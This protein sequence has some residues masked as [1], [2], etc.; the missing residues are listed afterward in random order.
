[1][2]KNLRGAIIML[3]KYF[4]IGFLAQLILFSTLFG[5]EVEAQLTN[6]VHA[7]LQDVSVKQVF[8]ALKKA[9]NVTIVYDGDAVK[10]NRKVH[11]Q[12][13]NL[14]AG[15]VLDKLTA[16]LGLVYKEIGN[17]IT[18]K[19]KVNET[20][21]PYN[22]PNLPVKSGNAEIINFVAPLTRVFQ[23]QISG[24]VKDS[25]GNALIGVT[26][27]V[28]GTTTG[29]TTDANGHFT[30]EALDNATLVFSYVGYQ[31]KEVTL[32]GQNTINVVLYSS[33]TG[34][35]E[36]I[37]IGYGTQKKSDLTGSVGSVDAKSIEE[38]SPSNVQEALQGKVPGVSVSLSSGRPGGAP[39]I[40]IR[41]FTS[42]TGSNNPLYV[43]DGVIIN[44][45][46][47]TNST[48][49]IDYLNPQ[50]IESIS[51]LKD[52][53]ATAI[54]G[55]RGANGVVI[56]T[57]KQPKKS[58]VRYSGSISIGTLPRE[59]PVLNSEEFLQLEDIAY[60]NA[61]KFGLQ[62]TI[63]DP[64]AKR[65][66]RPDLFDSN[67]NPLYNTNWQ[68]EGTRTAISHEQQLS[69]SGGDQ[70]TNYGGSLGYNS[71]QGIILAS[72]SKKYSG[73]FYVN[74]KINKWLTT[75]GSIN[76]VLSNQSYPQA[77]G[78]TGLV[79]SRQ[80]IESLPI[81]P[82]RY[83]DGSFGNN[84]DYPGM[85]GGGQPVRLSQQKGRHLKTNN[86]IGNAYLKFHLAEGLDFKTTLGINST[87]QEYKYF[88]AP[89]LQWISTDGNASVSN[90][91]IGSWQEESQLTYNTQISDN[92]TFSGL[93]AASW[94]KVTSFSSGA[95][96]S[97][98]NT[99]FYKYNN[100]GAAS[101]SSIPTSGR[102]QHTLNSYFGRINYA[103][104]DKYL[105]TA[106]GR[107]D[108]SS[109]FAKSNRY[110]FFPSGAFAWHLSNESF[111]K[112]N[113]TVSNLKLRISYGIT[114]NSN[115]PNYRIDSKLGNYSY[116][117]G[118]NLVSG[119][120]VGSLANSNL[121]WEK[122]KEVDFGIDLGLMKGRISFTG[123]IY[124]KKSSNILLDAPIPASSG[125]TSVIRNIG[126]MENRGIELS[127]HTR[128]IVNPNFSWTTTFNISMNRNKVLFLVG[129]QDI[130]GSGHTIIREG[131]SVNSFYG[132][133]TMGVW[134]TKQ[135]D[136]A[137]VYG[138]LPGDIIFE[139]MN[140]DGAINT[141]DMTIIGNGLPKGYGSL[142]NTFNYKSLQ[143]LINLQYE[144][145]N[146]VA[147]ESRYSFI[148]RTGIANSLREVLNAWTP[149]HQNTSIPQIRP[150][151][152]YVKPQEGKDSWIYNGSF[153]RAKRIMLSYQF[154]S[155]LARR[156][157]MKNINVFIAADNL[158]LIADYP[159]FDPETSSYSG[160]FT[161]GVDYYS[162]PK[163]RT[164]QFGLSFSL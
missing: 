155:E 81:I 111:L 96:V 164:F 88:A 103:I 98:L 99:L 40:H 85:D 69:F 23:S 136:E 109:R 116:I 153:I 58:E 82:V 87:T 80:I 117:F 140:N 19:R 28:K 141:L 142:I 115:I 29:T 148:D 114:G 162:Y 105:F 120:G 37:V 95:S 38:S 2:K 126:D 33:A 154:P 139:D 156:I 113:A 61:A 35:N 104:N 55:S 47:L 68:K 94:Q 124:Y 76:Y 18:I 143:L 10:L 64:V 145:G 118:G 43:V 15:E 12:G 144:F 67:G 125:Y 44:E 3:S 157:D 46:G 91:S 8:T 77:F 6:P 7:N 78:N 63:K 150:N 25:L 84:K 149:D 32:N 45:S 93:I 100:L 131:E 66:S 14:S 41:G 26:V 160:N 73:R 11:I 146:D 54:Y 137:A 39:S 112:D 59:I 129:G 53:S 17:T 74:S 101:T 135:K 71:Q 62:G 56:I 163:A 21:N 86:A 89:N 159:G 70:N 128:N 49:P 57:T 42:I 24:T 5:K 72:Y 122:D 158:F 83:P 147:W 22:L 123:D 36:V 92:Q 138:E 16:H 106:T 4:A 119:V 27:Q 130:L 97:D 161:K 51:V 9:A 20:S 48:S 152:G 107:F 31:D 1:M 65:A 132:Y 151:A 127:L 108:G 75:G 110:G 90:T 34:L 134:S 121:K 60:Q 102:N 50:D 30:I 79:P 13:A 133:L 52:A